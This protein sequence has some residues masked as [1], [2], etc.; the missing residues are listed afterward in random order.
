MLRLDRVQTRSMT[1]AR[2]LRSETSEPPS[3]AAETS[4]IFSIP[5]ASS[6]EKTLRPYQSR[7][8]SACEA[9]NTLVVLPTGSGKT[10]IAAEVIKRRPPHALFLVPTRHLVEQQAKALRAWA[11]LSIAQLR[12][13]DELQKKSFDVLVATPDAFGAAQGKEPA[14]LA[15]ACFQVIV[16]DEVHHVLKEHPYRKLAKSL[17]RWRSQSTPSPLGTQRVLGL[18]ASYSYEFGN[19]RAEAR[20]RE[21]SREL[22]IIKI[23]TASGQELEAGGCRAVMAEV[24]LPPSTVTPSGVLPEAD[25][26]QQPA[27]TFLLRERRNEGTDFSR[28]IMTCVRGMEKAIVAVSEHPAFASPLVLHGQMKACDWGAYAHGLA[29]NGGGG[30]RRG[31]RRGGRGGGGA[32]RRGCRTNPY[33]RQPSRPMLVELEHWYEAVKVLVVSWEERE[34]EAATILDIFGCTGSA[35][36]RA[37]SEAVWPG[38]VRQ[39]IWAFWKAVPRTFPRFEHLK[40]VLLDKYDH[41]GGDGSGSD[42]GEAF[43]GIVFVRQRVTTHVLAHVIAGDPR[44][45]PLFSAACLYASSSPATASL[46]LSEGATQDNLEAFRCGRKNLLLST[47]VAEEGIDIP[48]ANCVVRYDP[49]DHAVSMVQGRGRARGENSSFVVL[50]E[51]PDRTTADLEA[52]EQRQLWQLRNIEPES[53][54]NGGVDIVP[55]TAAAAA[56]VVPDPVQQGHDTTFGSD[57]AG[58][59][60]D[61]GDEDEPFGSIAEDADDATDS[62]E[63]SSSSTD[64]SNEPT[65]S[66]AVEPLSAGRPPLPAEPVSAGHGPDSTPSG[67]VGGGLAA[68]E[69]LEFLERE[70]RGVLLDVQEKHG[71]GVGVFPNGMPIPPTG[72][73]SAAGL[74]A[75][76]T[77]GVV[78]ETFNQDS[79]TRLWACTLSYKSVLRDVHAS[80]EAV[81]GKKMARKLAAARLVASLIIATDT[82]KSCRGSSAAVAMPEEGAAVMTGR[83]T[84][85]ASVNSES[86]ASSGTGNSSTTNYC[87]DGSAALRSYEAG[88]RAVLLDV[89]DKHGLGVG[90]SPNGTPIPPPGVLSA[91]DLFAEKTM[92]VVTETFEQDPSSRLWVC[93]LSYKSVLRDVHA[94]GQAVSGKKMARKLAAARLVADLLEAIST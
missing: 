15:W 17:R 30:G 44:L 67:D 53:Q 92:G 7:I 34:D 72:V 28:R 3:E 25:R 84:P 14:R 24:L 55:A 10:I 52:V 22:C 11:F 59:S 40:N 76:K 93:T 38:D 46:S 88:A 86:S 13:G 71:L 54:P 9:E 20:L 70:A 33:S 35:S 85:V 61:T 18:T 68:R 50:G 41:H 80:G 37:A 42:D 91:V 45:A 79:T 16:F 64:T 60:T 21:L 19:A 32:T 82:N 26:T 81:S 78:T 29:H 4:S 39:K 74:F 58:S 56:A 47:V 51:R 77:M 94:S 12:G 69:F 57:D 48:A 66:I 83:Q 49:M 87:N 8:A 23:E 5:S 63:A 27:T 31:G 90:V 6:P 1:R 2:A 65:A 73:L 62:S 36:H 75:E 89:Q 43:R